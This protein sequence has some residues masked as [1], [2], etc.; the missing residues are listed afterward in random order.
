MR[1]QVKENDREFEERHLEVLN[2]IESDDKDTV[3]LE[4]AAF[5]EHVNRVADIIERL[6]QL[7]ETEASV[8]SPTVVVQP[9]AVADPSLSLLKRLRYLNQEKEAIIESV[10]SPPTGP[11]ANPRVWLQECQ[12]EI[13]A[14]SSQ[15]AGIMGEILSLPG[16]ER[17]LINSTTSIKKA[18]KEANY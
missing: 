6:E 11:E 15:L 4:E 5:D 12:K 13:S 9:A 7:E 2:F 8:A 16:D 1:E 18:L 3:D 14:L 17:D 10:R